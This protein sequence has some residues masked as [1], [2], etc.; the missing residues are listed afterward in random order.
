[1]TAPLSIIIVH[2]QT[3]ELTRCCLETVARERETLAGRRPVTAVVVDNGS[4]DGSADEL[5][6]WINERHAGDW[7][8]LVRSRENLG[9]AGGNNLG[10]ESAA[11]DGPVLL[12]NSDTELA[13]GCLAA[14]LHALTA[15]P[16]IGLLSCRLVEPEG[17]TQMNAR[18]FPTPPRAVAAALGLPW[19]FPR[20]FGW[21]H[22]DD[23]GWDRDTEARDVDWLGGAFLLIRRDV[24]DAIGPLDEAFFFYGEDIE[25]CHRAAEAGFRRRYDPAGTTLHHGSG[26]SDVT[27]LPDADRRRH[28]WVGRYLVQRKL[29]GRLAER[30]LRWTDRAG[31]AARYLKARVR[32]D[33]EAAAA[34]AGVRRLLGEL[35][36]SSAKPPMDSASPGPDTG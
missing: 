24:L 23:P 14:C 33:P 6:A 25:F 36:G 19:K 15:D 31:W 18:P 32:R 11:G 2:Y 21:A 28:R 8:T 13:D 5:A 7:V 20:L 4:A 34:A 12:L 1:M 17:R 10:L 35:D 3:P 27:R 16:D 29:Y 26:S 30:L 9:F 22:P